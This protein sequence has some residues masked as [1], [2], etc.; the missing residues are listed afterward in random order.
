[1]FDRK[2]LNLPELFA[3]L[4]IFGRGTLKLKR[5][6]SR[7][8]GENKPC[9]RAF[10]LVWHPLSIADPVTA[11]TPKKS[12]TVRLPKCRE[13]TVHCS[14]KV[15]IFF[16]SGVLNVFLFFFGLRAHIDG[17]SEEL[18]QNPTF[19]WS[20]LILLMFVSLGG[21]YENLFIKMDIMGSDLSS[22]QCLY[23]FTVMFMYYLYRPYTSAQTLTFKSVLLSAFYKNRLPLIFSIPN[24]N[25]RNT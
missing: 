3:V 17:E 6:Y 15:G 2:S 9:C 12:R 10:Y 13:Q 20:Y 4:L 5:V 23:R 14:A 25:M 24:C 16:R 19:F 22:M 21:L 18:K 1:M 8:W 11:L 7:H